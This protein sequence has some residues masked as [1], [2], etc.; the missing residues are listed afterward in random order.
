MKFTVPELFKLTSQQKQK[1]RRAKAEEKIKADMWRECTFEP[2]T[3][4]AR[5]RELIEQLLAED[6]DIFED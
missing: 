1:S 4:E 5:N 2:Q 3:T 6:D